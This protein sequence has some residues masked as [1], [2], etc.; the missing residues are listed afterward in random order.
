M[1]IGA[2]RH[3]DAIR[4]SR[5]QSSHLAMAGGVSRVL[6]NRPAPDPWQRQM[7]TERE[8]RSGWAAELDIPRRQKSSG[9]RGG[10]R[11][12][13]VFVEALPM[14]KTAMQDSDQAVGQTAKR[15]G[16]VLASL[17][18]RGVTPPGTG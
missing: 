8:G 4:T 15:L 1:M 10:G 2:V 6:D 13:D 12:R 18:E 9:E 17:T 7:S 16:M 5:P 14:H 11:P 3:V